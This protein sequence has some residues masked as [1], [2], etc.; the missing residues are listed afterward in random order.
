MPMD[1]LLANK[2]A[3]KLLSSQNK[4]NTAKLAAMDI[5]GVQLEPPDKTITV[6]FK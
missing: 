3:M 5:P 2:E 4:E 1:K 6:T